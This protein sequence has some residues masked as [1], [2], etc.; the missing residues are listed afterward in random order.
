MTHEIDVQ[1]KF[2]SSDLVICYVVS[3]RTP[4]EL[5]VGFDTR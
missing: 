5:E 4:S 1:V 3:K 2:V